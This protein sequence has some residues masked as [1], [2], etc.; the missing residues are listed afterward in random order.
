M[1]I[2]NVIRVVVLEDE[3]TF[4]ENVELLLNSTEDICCIK[5]YGG[6]KAFLDDFKNTYP[7]VY[8]IDLHLLDGSGINVIQYIKKYRPEARCLVCSFFANEDKIFEALKNGADGYII[9]SEENNKML[10]AIRELHN[11]GVPMSNV[12]ARKVFSFFTKPEIKPSNLEHLS[13]REYEILQQLSKGLAYKEI[14]FNL[15]ISTE[16]VKKHIQNIYTKLHVNN[17]TEAVVK[18]LNQQEKEI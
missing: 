1:K 14:A 6:E 8:W 3:K 13:K 16:T 18:F 15:F 17:R 10:E 7:D 12:I 2:D 11:G 9:K 5:T 4:R